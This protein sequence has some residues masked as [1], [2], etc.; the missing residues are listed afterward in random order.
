MMYYSTHFIHKNNVFLDP[1]DRFPSDG[2]KQHV[3]GD[4]EFF[5]HE[6]R[7]LVWH[8]CPLNSLPSNFNPKNLLKLDMRD[9]H[10]QQLWEGIMVCTYFLNRTVIINF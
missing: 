5:S 3:R 8:K 2:C 7:F 10:I 4:F 6:L 9:S 1:E